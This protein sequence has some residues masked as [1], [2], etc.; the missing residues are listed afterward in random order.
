MVRRALMVALGCGALIGAAGCAGTE[1]GGGKDKKPRVGLV[2][3]N[4]EALFFKQMIQGAKKAAADEGVDLVITNGNNDP[5]AQTTAVENYTQQQLDAVIVNPIDADAIKP[6]IKTAKDGGLDVIAVDAVLND[7]DVMTEV[8]TDNLASGRQIGEFFTKWAQD[9]G[10]K[11]HTIGEVAALNST[12]Q[13]AR[14]NGF[15]GVVKNAGH[16]I[17]QVVDGKNVQETALQAAENL[18]T[19]QGSK[20]DAVYATG[21]PALLGTLAAAKSQKATGRL[22]IFAWDLTKEA[23]AGI[24][25]GY[26]KGVVQ[27][28]PYTEGVRAVEAAAQAAKGQTPPK[29]IKVPITIVTKDNVDRYRKLFR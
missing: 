16:R 21:E 26:V 8:G 5:S 19:G 6:A 24:D 2:V 25:A 4:Q 18:I 28:D 23:I 22:A 13:I 11:P 17:V 1:T 15:D 14:Q 10:G 9:K 3:I 12:V 29:R 27:Q 20:M 7:P